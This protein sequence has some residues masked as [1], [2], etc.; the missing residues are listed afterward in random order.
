MDIVL[1]VSSAGIQSGEALLV[2]SSSAQ[3]K[4]T[5]VGAKMERGGVSGPISPS[6]SKMA[7]PPSRVAE[8]EA[9]LGRSRGLSSPPASHL[10]SPPPHSGSATSTPSRSSVPP[11]RPSSDKGKGPSA[12]EKGPAA[13][14]KPKKGPASPGSDEVLRSFRE[15][16]SKTDCLQL[17]S[18]PAAELSSKGSV[19]M[20]EV[21]PFTFIALS[22]L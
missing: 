21:L 14:P 5:I 3:A 8:L 1:V 18:L 2:G 6:S 20:A 7:P 13:P 17:V 10:P 16:C 9:R 4:A 15:A 11:P 12:T 19:M 22:L